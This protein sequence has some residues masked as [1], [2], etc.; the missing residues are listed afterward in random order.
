MALQKDKIIGG[1]PFSY[2][3]I[4]KVT[5]DTIGTSIIVRD[6]KLYPV[7]TWN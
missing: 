6:K 4:K 7:Q 3:K 1:Q 2:H 5:I